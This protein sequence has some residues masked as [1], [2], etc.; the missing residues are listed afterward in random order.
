MPENA[1]ASACEYPDIVRG[2]D[3]VLEKTGYEILKLQA[4]LKTLEDFKRALDKAAEAA[5][6][7][8]LLISAERAWKYGSGWRNW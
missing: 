5:S 8:S 6:I 2:L 1:Q 7:G 3:P 4:N